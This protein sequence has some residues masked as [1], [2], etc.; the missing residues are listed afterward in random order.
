MKLGVAKHPGKVQRE[1]G[2]EFKWLEVVA[3]PLAVYRKG[4]AS[5][6][7][8]PIAVFWVTGIVSLLY[9]LEGGPLRDGET[10]WLLLGL[11][12]VMWAIAYVWGRLVATGVDEDEHGTARS[13]RAT[14][15]DPEAYTSDPM[16]EI[17]K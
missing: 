13:S 14:Q 8:A 16:D 15:V 2:M 5:M 10:N 6:C 11:G 17:R 7:T 1:T 12:A 4:S 3:P 9:G